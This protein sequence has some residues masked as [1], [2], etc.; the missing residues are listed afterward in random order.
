MSIF[1]DAQYDAVQFALVRA[2]LGTYVAVTAL[3]LLPYASELYGGGPLSDAARP[4]APLSDFLAFFSLPYASEAALGL[5]A[6][7]GVLTATGLFRQYAAL[8]AFIFTVLLFNR[9]PLT[10][11]PSGP[12]IA[13]LLLLFAL[14]PS[15]ERFSLDRREGTAESWSMPGVAYWG[16]W[17][18]LAVSLTVSGVTRLIDSPSWQDGSAVQHLLT[19]TIAYDSP[20]VA[21]LLSL[22]DG[23]LALLSYAAAGVFALSVPAL[24]HPATRRAVWVL[25]VGSFLFVL[26][27]LDLTEVALGMLIYFAFLFERRTALQSPPQTP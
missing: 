2:A 3:L 8:V 25:W 9:N 12:F 20:L 24:F 22:P 21:F 5:L 19:L 7:A 11:D 14:I 27:T 1:R 18:V 6:T 26:A 15:G 23:V 17:L 4:I 10:E 16:A 13:L